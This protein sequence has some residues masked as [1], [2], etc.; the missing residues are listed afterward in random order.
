MTLELRLGF[1]LTFVL[2]LGF[3][4]FELPSI[5]IFKFV[6]S[7]IFTFEFEET[8]GFCFVLE[9][10]IVLGLVFCKDWEA[11]DTILALLFV[12][13]FLL[14]SVLMG[15]PDG[16]GMIGIDVP[17][18]LVIGYPWLFWVLILLVVYSTNI[19]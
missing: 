9:L 6:F 10:V 7:F 16:D 17:I 13:L 8:D 18:L 11:I 1:V 15:I 4:A 2:V 19:S 5:L 14:L 12:L 3:I